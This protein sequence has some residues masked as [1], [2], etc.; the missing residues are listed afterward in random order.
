M[1]E[2]YQ[3]TILNI[4]D[5]VVTH[6]FGSQKK[7]LSG[8]LSN[9][10]KQLYPH[11]SRTRTSTGYKTLSSGA[12]GRLHTEFQGQVRSRLDLGSRFAL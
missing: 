2:E 7:G 1:F 9:K 12:R 10:P 3:D 8:T 5:S 11:P 4:V 6:C